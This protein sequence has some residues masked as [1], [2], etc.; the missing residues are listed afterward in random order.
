MKV[1]SRSVASSEDNQRWVPGG[2]HLG[3]D[4]V[5]WADR[6]I[7]VND[8]INII[9]TACDPKRIII[10][11]PAAKGYVDDNHVDVLVVIRRGDIDRIRRDLTVMLAMDDID[12]NVTVVNER[13]F[14]KHATL[15]YT[16][17]YDAI[18]TG[19]DAE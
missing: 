14:N 16:E 3:G 10:Y 15:S 19:Y 13:L 8:A 1:L 7:L 2:T 18:K 17:T 6:P 9:R 5:S 4:Y 11:G 12:G